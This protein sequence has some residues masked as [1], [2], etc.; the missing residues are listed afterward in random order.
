MTLPQDHEMGKKQTASHLCFNQI[1]YYTNKAINSL[2]EQTL[3]WFR[4]IDWFP[5]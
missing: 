3:H 1:R 4:I 2:L 5:N